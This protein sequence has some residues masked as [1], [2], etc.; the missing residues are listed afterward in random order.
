M[1]N[2]RQEESFR[3]LEAMGAAVFDRVRNAVDRR[4]PC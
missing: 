3:R 1:G 4:P 2:G